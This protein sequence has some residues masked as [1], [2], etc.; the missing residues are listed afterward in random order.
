MTKYD[1]L[2]ETNNTIYACRFDIKNLY[3]TF[4]PILF[5]L[6]KDKKYGSDLKK[7]YIEVYFE[8]NLND[9]KSVHLGNWSQTG[10]SIVMVIKIASTYFNNLNE[11]DKRGLLTD[12]FIEGFARFRSKIKKNN[13][14]SFDINWEN[15]K[16][17]IVNAANIYNSLSEELSNL[18]LDVYEYL[19]IKNNY[20][21]ESDR[22]DSI[23]QYMP[24]THNFL[25]LKF[26]DSR[27]NKTNHFLSRKYFDT[28]NLYVNNFI[29]EM[30]FYDDKILS[31]N[32]NFV[33]D[34]RNIAG[35][36]R[37]IDQNGMASG[38]D[39]VP[40]KRDEYEAYHLRLFYQFDVSK[41]INKSSEEKALF[42]KEIIIEACAWV[43][44]FARNELDKELSQDYEKDIKKM[45]DNFDLNEFDISFKAEKL[46][47]K[48]DC[49]FPELGTNLEH[50][51]L[52]TA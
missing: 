12:L 19:S 3:N 15:I 27:Q 2:K 18:K 51:K 23:F 29:R 20:L 50:L 28:I 37:F 5:N 47:I 25:L 40:V 43:Y 52:I 22:L 31:C 13:K 1:L 45:F 38:V 6:S 32:I 36:D 17:D 11:I 48:V 49:F 8:D 41:F 4:L 9:D 7:M 26:T 14:R 42:F 16:K 39:V 24:N 10:K 35:L 46:G 21:I 44:K 33:S 34:T 30:E